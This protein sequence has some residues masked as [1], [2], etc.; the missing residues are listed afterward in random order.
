M[1]EDQTPQPV[2]TAGTET[3]SL[4]PPAAK[5][6]TWLVG[7]VLISRKIDVVAFAAFFI[8]IATI[9]L[10]LSA[11]FK[12]AKLKLLPP[13]QIFIR[14]DDAYS[15]GA[16]R[17]RFGATLIY[18][19]NGE[20]GY[21]A[22]VRRELAHIVVGGIDFEQGWDNFVTYEGWMPTKPEPAKPFSVDG[23]ESKSHQT[24]FIPW[25]RRCLKSAQATCNVL[26]NHIHWEQFIN[27][28]RRFVQAGQS[29]FEFKF[30]AE[31]IG[32]EPA[33]SSC[34]IAIDS[35]IVNAID[36]HHGYNPTCFSE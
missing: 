18:L 3:G 22:I 7:G 8:S 33:A 19:N 9:T 25:P 10:Q 12:G 34:K 31:V 1:T 26:G 2:P 30:T 15:D 5:P 35:A 11:Y 4:E 20:K 36:Y 27:V 29:E 16:P 24:D 32:G 21:A 28:L 13:D 17:A 23:G 14:K 6:D